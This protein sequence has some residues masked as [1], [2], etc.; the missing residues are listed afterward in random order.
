MIIVVALHTLFPLSY[1]YRVFHH[2]I[3]L[4]VLYLM[5]CMLVRVTKT[6]Y[7]ILDSDNRFVK[8]SD[9]RFAKNSDNR[10]SKAILFEW[11]WRRR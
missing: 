4:I 8:N 6:I 1:F 11:V 5:Y 9:N 2:I 7:N 10:F 3:V